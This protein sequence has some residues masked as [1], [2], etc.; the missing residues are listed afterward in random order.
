MMRLLALDP[1][2]TT[3]W[4]SIDIPDVSKDVDLTQA[5]GVGQLGPHD[6]HSELYAMMELMQTSDFVL[7]TERF[8]YR[9][10][11]R[12]G[13]QLES[14]EYIGVAKMF[15]QERMRGLGQ[16]AVFQNASQAKG[17]VEDRHIKALGLWSPGMK[18]AM[19]ALR[20]LIY[21]VANDKTMRPVRLQMQILTTAY[22]TGN[23]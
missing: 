19:D 21:F 14:R 18:H 17:F 11:S 5:V 6:H 2:V 12:A 23:K 7:I 3:G 4:A 8:E 16:Q 13:L 20:H 22:R 10:K 9:N 1:G 15:Y